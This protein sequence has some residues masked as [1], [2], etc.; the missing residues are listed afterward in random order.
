M[1]TA[2]VLW[3]AAP[4]LLAA[5]FGS[6]GCASHRVQAMAY[7]NDNPYAPGGVL[8]ESWEQKREIDG[9]LHDSRVTHTAVG[10][11]GGAIA[12]QAIGRDTEGTL[13]GVGIGTAAGLTSGSITDHNK[14]IEHEDHMTRLANNWQIEHDQ[15]QQNQRDVAL[16]ATITEDQMQARLARLEAARQALA[17]RDRN[18]DRARKLREIDRE[19]DRLNNTTT[20]RGG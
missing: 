9:L 19:I 13:W 5:V 11:G 6:G 18:V 17:E 3:L 4:V 14:Q 15:E 7:S 10:A 8:Y 16:G 12:G 20:T 2:H 1:K